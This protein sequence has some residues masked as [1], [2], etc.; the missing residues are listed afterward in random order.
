[1][2]EWKVLNSMMKMNGDLDDMGNENVVQSNGY[3]CVVMY[4]KLLVKLRK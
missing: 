2:K 3:E 4:L 1:L